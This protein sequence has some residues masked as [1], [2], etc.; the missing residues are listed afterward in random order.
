M[1]PSWL[2]WHFLDALRSPSNRQPER[3]IYC[4]EVLAARLGIAATVLAVVL[5]GVMG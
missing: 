5:W 1:N 3:D 2:F 4:S